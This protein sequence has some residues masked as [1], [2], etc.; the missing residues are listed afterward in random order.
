MEQEIKG[1]KE[2]ETVI[3]C[4]HTPEQNYLVGR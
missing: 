4:P 3:L 2:A 1:Q